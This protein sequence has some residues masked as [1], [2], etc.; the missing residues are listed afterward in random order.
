MQQYSTVV[1]VI[2]RLIE[3]CYCVLIS[4][5]IFIVVYFSL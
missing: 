1:H 5:F 2:R 3:F 4:H